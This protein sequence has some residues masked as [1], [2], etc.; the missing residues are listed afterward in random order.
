MDVPIIVSNPPERTAYDNGI[1]TWD[2]GTS[3]LRAQSRKTGIIKAVTGVLF[4]N[5]ERMKHIDSIRNAP[6]SEEELDPHTFRAK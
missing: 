1:S 5:A 2:T 3:L 6:I 4:R